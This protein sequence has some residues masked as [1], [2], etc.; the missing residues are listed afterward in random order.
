MGIFDMFSK[1]PQEKPEEKTE[2][3]AAAPAARPRSMASGPR[4]IIGIDPGTRYCGYGIVDGNGTY[5][6]SGRIDLTA[7]KKPLHER[8]AE[9]HT[10]LESVI[11]QYRPTEA[12]I[13][14]IFF[15]HNVRAALGLGHARGAILVTASIAGLKIAEYT[16]VEVKKAVTGNGRAEKEQVAEM[17]KKLL[18]YK[19]ELSADSADAL[20]LCLCHMQRDSFNKA[21]AAQ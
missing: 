8:L 1:K 19:G 14:K 4:R 7:G 2:A 15:S 5:V 9:L 11:E 20:A 12:A 13:E 21:V 18:N 10:E 17:V 6:A 16:A 3:A